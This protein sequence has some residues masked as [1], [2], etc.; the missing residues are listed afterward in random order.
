GVLRVEGD[1]APDQGQGA[2]VERRDGH[3]QRDD[4]DPVAAGR[5]EVR[6][7][8]A[9]LEGDQGAGQGAGQ[10]GEEPPGLFLVDRVG[11]GSGDVIVPGGRRQ[12]AGQ[13][14]G[15]LADPDDVPVRHAPDLRL[16]RGG[17]LDLVAAQDVLAQVHGEAHAHAAGGA[18]EAGGEADD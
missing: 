15:R 10:G 6:V 18:G 8:A 3:R 7:E 16:Q 9:Q 14:T 1:P 17:A 12:R 4:T 13:G 2:A 5:V 11:V